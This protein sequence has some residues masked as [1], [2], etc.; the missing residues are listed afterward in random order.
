MRRLILLAAVFSIAI[1][2]TAEASTLKVS[3]GVLSYSDSSTTDTNNVTIAP[4]PD[5][6]HI[7]VTETGK[8]SRNRAITITSDGSCT[9]TATTGTCAAAGVSSITVD[10]GGANDIIAQSTSLPS[11]LHGGAGN[12]TIT[13]GGGDDTFSEEP[14]AD[15][16]H[17][18][19]G[20]DTVD[21]SS[22]TTPVVVSLDD[23][24]GDGAANE[25]DNVGS[26]IEM[27][28]GGSGNDTITGSAA[29]N[30][31][32]GG[33]GDDTLTGGAGND[34]LDGGT[35]NDVLNGGD[36][37][38]TATYANAATGVTVSL[39]GKPD[40]GVQGEADNVDTENVIGSPHDD[41]LIGNAGAN[42]LSGGDGNDRILGGTG[43]DV[44]DGG[45]GDDIIQSLDGTRET[46]A[47]GDGQD[48]VVSDRADVRTDCEYIKYRPLA[49]SA[50][51][52]HLSHG[53]VRAPVRCSPA[54]AVGCHGH[55][56]LRTG[57]HTL[58]T[59]RYHLSSGRRWIARIKLSRKARSYVAH[60][61]LTTASL[62][63]SDTD[64][65][66]DRNRT[67]QTIRIAS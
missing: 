23:Q 43:A 16:F 44:L 21:Y 4:T 28:V 45:N 34:L 2:A 62:V 29:D 54:T 22:A 3:G 39:D 18:G 40:D 30:V 1:S 14:G 38:D 58:G 63:V 52:L 19:G 31:L 51:A 35:G 12:D 49:A 13:G 27:V 8:T 25:N 6:S 65:S 24:P 59:L 41:V 7:T 47:C 55:I 60:H 53:A 17:G 67:T 48:G 26:D 20:I 64:A 5:G 46:V 32:V 37:T 9:A 66:G 42:S 11:T 36:G 50:T 56:T 57:R 10:T 15:V 33:A 61:R